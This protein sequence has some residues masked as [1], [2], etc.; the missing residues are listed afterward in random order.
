MARKYKR[1]S[2]SECV[3]LKLWAEGA[4]KQILAPHI[5]PYVDALAQS[6][7]AERAYL[8][9]VQNEY[10]QSIGNWRLPDDEEPA[11]PLPDYD[12]KLLAPVEELSVEDSRLKSTVI[13]K[14]NKVISLFFSSLL[15]LSNGSPR[16]LQ[17][18]Q[19]WLKYCAHKLQ[20]Q[21]A[22]TMDP[23]KNPYAALLAKLSGIKPPPIH[24]QQGWQQMMHE[25]YKEDVAPA[26]EAAW[27]ERLAAGVATTEKNN[28]PF[29]GEVTRGLFTSL[30]SDIIMSPKLCTWCIAMLPYLQ[31]P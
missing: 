24:A 1:M 28:A 16:N 12:P 27:S 20:S 2:K 17:A 4:R 21:Y 15:S 29:R 31:G 7:V 19:C 14:K 3:N 6:C 18:I 30:S 11:L 10:H 26:V 13:S 8:K 25:R 9:R 23:I 22:P 5:E